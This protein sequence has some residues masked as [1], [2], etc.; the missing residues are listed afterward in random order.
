M[1]SYH[2]NRFGQ[3][4]KSICVWLSMDN[5]IHLQVE[6]YSVSNLPHISQESIP[7]EK[8]KSTEGLLEYDAVGQYINKIVIKSS[9]PTRRY[10]LSYPPVLVIYTY[11][12]FIEHDIIIHVG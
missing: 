5:I 4:Q 3:N 1:K 10:L 8:T 6:R 7:N 11:V 12:L 9:L 2:F